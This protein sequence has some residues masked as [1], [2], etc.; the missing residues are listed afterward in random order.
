MGLALV[1][2]ADG[3]FV[4]DAAGQL[5]G[6]P[7]LALARTGLPGTITNGNTPQGVFTIVGAGTATNPNIGPTPYLHSKLPIEATPAEF[8]HA[9]A[10]PDAA[11]SEAVYESF[12][13]A[14]WRA[15]LPIKEAWLAGRA[16]RDAAHSAQAEMWEL[17]VAAAEHL[18]TFSGGDGLPSGRRVRPV[19]FHP[20][21]PWR[22]S[23]SSTTCG[24]LGMRSI[25]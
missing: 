10:A 19:F 22:A 9:E 3:R 16:G 24:V 18:V 2:A 6:S 14:S 8:E 5:F 4:R 7:Q 11:W 23:S 12:L 21:P 25:P 1:R 13:P 20:R 17:H 15:F